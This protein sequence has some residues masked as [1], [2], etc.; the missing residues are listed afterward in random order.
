MRLRIS[1]TTNSGTVI[2]II[3]GKD[4]TKNPSF[5]GSLINMTPTNY[6]NIMVTILREKVKLSVYTL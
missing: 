4:E 1:L 5:I 6:Y 2:I 3:A